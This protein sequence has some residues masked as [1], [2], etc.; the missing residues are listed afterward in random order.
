LGPSPARTTSFARA[1]AILP[2]CPA[3][4]ECRNS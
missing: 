2:G 3:P 1:L 4:R